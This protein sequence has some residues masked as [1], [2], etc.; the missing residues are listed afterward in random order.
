MGFIEDRCNFYIYKIVKVTGN[1]VRYSL[2]HCTQIAETSAVIG[3]ANIDTS[4]NR[5]MLA[6][7]FYKVKFRSLSRL[8]ARVVM[9]VMF[10]R[11][12]VM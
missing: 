3:K 4:D 9:S 12:L 7:F 11:N 5:K 6:I 10:S 8:S 1:N 2:Q